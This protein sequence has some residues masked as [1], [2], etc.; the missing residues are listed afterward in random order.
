M[1]SDEHI[2]SATVAD[3]SRETKSAFMWSP[4]R[5][6]LASLR[7]YQYWESYGS[8]G[9]L[10]C[11][12]AVVRHRFWSAVTGCDLPINTK[13]GGGLLM[14][15]PNGIVIHPMCN[16]GPNCLIF[17]QVT[18]GSNGSSSNGGIPTLGGHVDVGAG[19]KILG[20]VTIGDN[21]VI[22]ANAVVLTDVPANAAAVGI[23]ARVIL[24]A[25]RDLS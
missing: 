12:I 1:R 18:L 10:F 5:S 8:I 15:H 17:Q 19:A 16:I 4:S 21:A 3:W 2:P 25:D 22:G 13:I 9:L 20:P 7:S 6:L 11:K 14:P 23:P 24:H